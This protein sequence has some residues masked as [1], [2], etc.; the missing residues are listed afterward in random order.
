MCSQVPFS[1]YAWFIDVFRCRGI[2]AYMN[3]SIFV[4]Q[5]LEMRFLLVYGVC[6]E[7]HI[8]CGSLD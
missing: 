3:C 7:N 1:K 2:L 6:A 4:G 8:T 5:Q